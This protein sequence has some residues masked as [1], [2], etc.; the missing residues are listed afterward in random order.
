MAEKKS[1]GLF[2]VIMVILSCFFQLSCSTSNGIENQNIQADQLEVKVMT[3]NIR[4]Y[5]AKDGPDNWQYR[6]QMV[7]NVIKNNRVDIIGFQEAHK[8]QVEQIQEQL[9]EFGVLATYRNGKS[10]GPSNALFYRKSRFIVDS[11]DTFWFSD[12]P[13]MPGSIG[14]GN[15]SSRFCTWARLIE[16]KSGKCFYFFNTHLDHRSQYSRERSAIFVTKMINLRKDKSPFILTGDMNAREDN[17]VIRFFKGE[18]L[19]LDNNRYG[20]LVPVVDTFR[21]KHGTECDAGTFNGFGK[22]EKFSKIDYVFVQEST[23]ILDAKVI[24]Y[25][26]N[27]HYPSDH[28]PVTARIQ[29]H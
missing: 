20:T 27:G 15:K 2:L 16:K 1:K 23:T 25:N 19:T 9:D 8:L 22:Y 12:T 3:F 10:N 21:I 29:F 26:E 14:W 4:Y 17:R 7:I 6:R 5:G 11:W 18:E 13:E 28:C 24:K